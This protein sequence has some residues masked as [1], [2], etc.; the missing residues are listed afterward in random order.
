MLRCFSSGAFPTSF[1]FHG[2]HNS[3][4]Q[5]SLRKYSRLALR[6]A[7][8]H[9]PCAFYTQQCTTRRDK[10]HKRMP[11][12]LSTPLLLYLQ[13]HKTSPHRK[14]LQHCSRPAARP[15]AIVA[16]KRNLPPS[17]AS[18]ATIH[19]RIPGCPSSLSNHFMHVLGAQRENSASIHGANQY[20]THRITKLKRKSS[21]VRVLC[22]IL[23]LHA[24]GS[25]AQHTK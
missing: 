11:T 12:K 17:S 13:S 16:K 7:R 25:T 6:C 3:R 1:S 21:T 15:K 8:G 24:T 10:M 14:A 18:G 5:N 19:A 22:L 2:I 20:G 4:L 23:T 9:T